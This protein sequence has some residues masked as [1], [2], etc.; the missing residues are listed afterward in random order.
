MNDSKLVGSSDPSKNPVW[1]ELWRKWPAHKRQNLA[2][3]DWILLNV[4]QCPSE[5]SSHLDFGSSEWAHQSLPQAPNRRS[6]QLPKH[7]VI[8]KVLGTSGHR[9]RNMHSSVRRSS[10]L[11]STQSSTSSFPPT[12]S[13]ISSASTPSS[14]NCQ[15]DGRK[16][17]AWTCRRVL[18]S[19]KTRLLWSANW[20]SMRLLALSR[21]LKTLGWWILSSSGQ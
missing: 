18:S 16:K 19:E 3:L 1:T 12:P 4:K 11:H 10:S 20:T 7:S 15:K 14:R 2:I 6:R 13:T 8:M 5:E 17:I 21:C 9:G